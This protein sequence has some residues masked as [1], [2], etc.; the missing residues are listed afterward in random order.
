MQPNDSFWLT[1]LEIK[2]GIGV[3]KGKVL[4]FLKD[5]EILAKNGGEAS[6][7]VGLYLYAI[8]EF[9]KLLLL[10]D[11]LNG[12]PMNGKYAVDKSIFGR[13]SNRTK[14]SQAHDTKTRRA[15]QTLPATCGT[16][17]NSVIVKNATSSPGII[18]SGSIIAPDVGTVPISEGIT[19]IVTDTQA[20]SMPF[21]VM[22]R[23]DGFYVDWEETG[24]QWVSDELS[25]QGGTIQISVKPSD[26]LPAIEAFRSFL[27]SYV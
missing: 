25:Y 18:H 15:L 9:G 2:S 21:T 4:R 17:V 26:L 11:A 1:D 20:P 7:Y 19:G 8:E 5:A 23:M 3:L 24:R 16:R 13:G 10:Q 22:E 27:S 6:H 12:T 14:R